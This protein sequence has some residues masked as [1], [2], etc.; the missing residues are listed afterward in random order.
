MSSRFIFDIET[1]SQHTN[2]RYE[3]GKDDRLSLDVENGEIVLYANKDA[4]VSLAKILLQI[5]LGN[6]PAG[7]HLHVGQDF[8]PQN[9]AFRIQLIKE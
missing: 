8:E 1:T 4:L 6:Y 9:H 2:L 3:V 5:G 7:F